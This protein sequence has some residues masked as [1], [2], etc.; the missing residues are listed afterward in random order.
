MATAFTAF[1]WRGFGEA[2]MPAKLAKMDVL[3]Q[4]SALASVPESEREAIGYRVLNHE[5]DRLDMD[6]VFVGEAADDGPEN[7]SEH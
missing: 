5:D 6:D 1:N 7:W 4:A 2:L 3:E